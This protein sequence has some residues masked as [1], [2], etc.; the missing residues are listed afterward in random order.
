MLSGCSLIQKQPETV[1]VTKTEYITCPIISAC[2]QTEPVFKSNGDLLQAYVQV[3]H[4]RRQCALLVDLIVDC[5]TEHLKAQ[6]ANVE[7]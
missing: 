2:D 5:Q 6:S 3:R 4:E 1:V 7:N